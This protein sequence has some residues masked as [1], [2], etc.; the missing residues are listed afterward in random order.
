MVGGGLCTP[1]GIRPASPS[2]KRNKEESRKMQQ[3]AQKRCWVKACVSI[4]LPYKHL[5][6]RRLKICVYW[7]EGRGRT[8]IISPK[9]QGK[10]HP[11]GC[12]LRWDRISYRVARETNGTKIWKGVPGPRNSTVL[13]E[14]PFSMGTWEGIKPYKK[15][16]V[17]TFSI[18]PRKKHS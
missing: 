6:Q 15:W 18:L 11:R 10:H 13:L 7:G 8:G 4:H 16:W 17:S 14:Q 12:G 9:D 1:P 5:C 2:N 3:Q